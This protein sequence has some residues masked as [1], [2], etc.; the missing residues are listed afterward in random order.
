MPD[1]TD[2]LE[3]LASLLDRGLLTREQFNEQR[4]RLLAETRVPSTPPPVDPTPSTPP[5]P[6]PRRSDVPEQIGAYTILGQIGEGGMG[7]VYRARHRSVTIARRHGGEVAIKVMHAQL[8]RSPDFQ[9]RFDREA[10]LG[11]SLDHVG[12]VKVHD[13]VIDGPIVALVMELVQGRPLS[14][15]IGTETG[16]IPW[17]RARP[18]FEQL[19]HIVGY[20]HGQ[21]V[22]HRDL[23]PENVMLMPD[24][25]LKVLDFGIAK[26][27][28]SQATMTGTGMGTADY[29]APEQH[30]DAKN[31]DGRA[32]IYSLGMTLY[33]MLAGQL[34]WGDEMDVVGVLQRKLSGELPPPTTFYPD[35]PPEIVEVVRRATAG[36]LDQRFGSVDEILQALGMD[37][38]GAGPVR[39]APP[40]A[41]PISASPAEPVDKVAE[42]ASKAADQVGPALR[43]IVDA[44]SSPSPT[45]TGAPTRLRRLAARLID[46]WLIGVMAVIGVMVAEVTWDEDAGVGVFVLGLLFLLG[47]NCALLGRRGQTVGKVLVKIKIVRSSGERAGPARLIFVRGAPLSV[48]AVIPYLGWGGLLLDYLT[49]LR[50]DHRCLH[51]LLADTKVVS[52]RSPAP[53]S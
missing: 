42:M 28:G 1:I 24:G 10:N 53:G 27:A 41:E 33:E 50:H 12:I 13:L 17:E 46:W 36:Q 49:V 3:R 40:P 18:M 25:Q 32:D 21:G 39:P 5:P 31:V 35:I 34:P 30:T 6:P 14:D 2:K 11:L 37:P 7:T 47:V 16:P 8:A 51:D 43:G 15:V 48:L 45:P 19:L 22:I 29:M 44:V 20:A 26:E 4:D 23:K 52:A 38:M 9:A